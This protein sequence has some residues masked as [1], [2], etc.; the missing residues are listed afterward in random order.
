MGNSNFLAGKVFALKFQS[1]ERKVVKA[2]TPT[3]IFSLHNNYKSN[4][5]FMYRGVLQR[6]RVDSL[7]TVYDMML[8]RLGLGRAS[9]PSSPTEVT[10]VTVRDASS[11]FEEFVECVRSTGLVG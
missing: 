2:K 4:E 3:G 8:N 9:R 10:A 5:L 7:R 1:Q 6:G 11:V